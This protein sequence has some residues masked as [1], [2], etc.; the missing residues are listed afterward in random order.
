[1]QVNKSQL[2]RGLQ[3]LMQRIPSEK[4]KEGLISTSSPNVYLIQATLDFIWYTYED[5]PAKI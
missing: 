5:L 3:I 4:A 2:M 1:L